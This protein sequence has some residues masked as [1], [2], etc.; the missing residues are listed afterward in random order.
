MIGCGLSFTFGS[1]RLFHS[2]S[3]IARI[4]ARALI[5]QYRHREDRAAARP[6]DAAPVAVVARLF[7]LLEPDAGQRGS[8]R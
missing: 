4:A 3:R 2:A 7:P 8:P 6:A 5:A 1:T